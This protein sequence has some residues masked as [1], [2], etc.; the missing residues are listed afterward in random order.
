MNKILRRILLAGGVALLMNVCGGML[1]AQPPADAPPPPAADQPTAANT[2]RPADQP[3]ANA[4]NRGGGRGM[5]GNFDPAR[6]QEMILQRLQERLGATDEEWTA[7]KPQLEEVLKI[8]AKSR[9]TGMMGAFGGRRG[10]RGGRGGQN[11]PQGPGAGMAARM[12]ENNPEM[13]A[14]ATAADSTTTPKAE[15]KAKL[16]AYR[17]A[18]KHNAE[19]LK[20]ARENLRKLVTLR[21]EAILVLAGI[22]D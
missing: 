5:R 13:A 12:A 22:L 14:L 11:P 17:D 16:K 7:M 21:Q 4:P 8:Q 2:A 1:L 18:V 9:M 6:M 19:A 15:L 3:N 20:T 10:G